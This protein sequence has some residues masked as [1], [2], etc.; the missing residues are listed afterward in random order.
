M[1]ERRYRPPNRWGCKPDD[2]VCVQHDV[3]RECPHGCRYALPHKC[4][5]AWV[6]PEGN[7]ESTA[8]I[9]AGEQPT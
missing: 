9:A 7:A 8:K 4:N 1:S 3:P 5:G 2:D 6:V